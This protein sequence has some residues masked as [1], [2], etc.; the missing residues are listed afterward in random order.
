MFT[1]KFYSDDGC[2]QVIKSAE[3]FTI[4]RAPRDEG[5][6]EIT[7]HQ[8]SQADDCRIDIGPVG[9]E[10][11]E[12]WPPIYQTAIIENALGKTTEIIRA[13]PPLKALA[14]A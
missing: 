2:R 4:L 5:G 9:T 13:G 12:G 1:V 6:T 10:R 8:K 3:S 7:L 14:A 11:L